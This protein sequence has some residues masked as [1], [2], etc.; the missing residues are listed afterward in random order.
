MKTLTVIC[1]VYNEEQTIALFFERV[2]KVFAGLEGRYRTQLFFLDNGCTDRSLEVIRGLADAHPWVYVWVFSRNFGYQCAVD[3]GLRL[4]P[5]DLFVVIDVDCEDPPEMIPTFLAEHEKGYDIVYG[6][7]V[8]RPENA[9]LKAGRKLFYRLIRVVADDNFVLDMAEF[10]LIT[11]EVRDAIVQ[12]TNSFPFVRASIG[13]IGFRRKAI[14]YRRE[15]RVAGRTHYNFAGLALF[16]IAGIL[17]ASTFPLRVATYLLPFLVAAMA[18]LVVA[19]AAWDLAWTTPAI[20]ALGFAYCGYTLAATALYVAR[21]YKNG[22]LRPN[23]IVRPQL[24]R[25]PADATPARAGAD[26]ER[27]FVVPSL[28]PAARGPAAVVASTRDREP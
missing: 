19:G 25:L 10:G 6:E 2:A 9:V 11:A 23:V 13:R 7:R 8:D 26:G 28:P 17:S 27:A 20:C 4:C 1:S 24:C 14:P 12:D 16:A 22:L 21:I 18:A 3:A 5:G 15:S